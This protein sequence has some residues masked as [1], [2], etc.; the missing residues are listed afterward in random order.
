MTVAELIKALEGLQLKH[1]DIEVLAAWDWCQWDIES[2]Y[3]AKKARSD[4]LVVIMDVQDGTTRE[5]WEIR[6]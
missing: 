2:V 1:G 3:L 4:V 6:S 5:E